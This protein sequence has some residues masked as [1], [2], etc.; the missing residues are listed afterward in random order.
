MRDVRVLCR[1]PEWQEV[2]RQVV[3][4]GLLDEEKLQKWSELELTTEVDSLELVEL[5]IAMEEAFGITFE[6]L[7]K[8][9]GLR[10]RRR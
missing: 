4:K 9:S 7:D 1:W 10:D 5:T 2:R 3:G 8:V 6:G